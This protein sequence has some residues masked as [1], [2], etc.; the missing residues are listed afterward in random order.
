M[1]VDSVRWSTLLTNNFKEVLRHQEL[2][3]P[4]IH[5]IVL[6]IN[7]ELLMISSPNADQTYN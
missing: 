7:N 1:E 2:V 5:Y 6:T 4:Y 3:L